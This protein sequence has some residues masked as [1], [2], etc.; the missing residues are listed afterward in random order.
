MTWPSRSFCDIHVILTINKITSVT[1]H[2]F[3]MV[4]N[5]FA[6]SSMM[7]EISWEIFTIRVECFLAEISF[8]F[9]IIITASTSIRHP[10][11][12]DSVLMTR[13]IELYI[14]CAKKQVLCDTVLGYIFLLFHHTNILFTTSS[15]S[16]NLRT[17]TVVTLLDC[18]DP[19]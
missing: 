8:S 15:N 19:R 11:I 4:L 2:T 16:N 9:V 12:A 14:M 1:L 3:Q 5:A 10:L 18:F 13:R 6:V 17:R 7:C